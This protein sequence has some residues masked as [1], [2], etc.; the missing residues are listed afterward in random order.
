MNGAWARNAAAEAPG[1]IGYWK[2]S[3]DCRDHSGQGHDGVNHGVN[4]KTSEFNGDNAYVEVPDA[5]AFH[6]GDHDFSI[7]AEVSTE[8]DITD[9]FGDIVTKFDPATR[10]GINFTLCSSNPGYNSQSNVRNLFFGV[11]HGADGKWTP[12]GRPG[13]D[14]THISDA[15]TVFD[16]SLYAGTTDGANESDWAHVYRYAGDSV[17]ED[18]GRL[19]SGRTRGVYA[20]VVHDGALYAATCASH[21]EQKPEMDPGRVYRYRG[22]QSWEDLGAPGKNRRVNSLA[23]YNGKLYA[24][25]FNIYYS[26]PREPGHIYVYEGGQ[27]WRECGE[28]QGW[29]HAMA[30]HNGRL[31]AA[32]PNGEVF[33][34]DGSS[35]TNLGNPHGSLEECNQI[36]SLGVYQ[37]KLYAGSWPKGKVAVLRDGKWVDLGRLGD[38]TEVIALTVYNGSFYAGSIPRAEVFRFDPGNKWTS[39]GRLF[40]PPDFEP[41]PVGAGTKD[42]QDWTRA[43]SLAVY[44]GKLFASTATC[45]REMIQPP[46]A[47]EARGTVYAYTAGAGVSLDRDMGAGWKHV[48][49]VREGN[50]LR[51]YVDGKLAAKAETPEKPLDVSNDKPL[52][53]GAGPQAPFAG[54]IREVRLY[55]RTLK[56]EEIQKLNQTEG[57]AEANSEKH[58]A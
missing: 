53:I 12:C 17:W 30:V 4:L 5:E 45:Y 18:C 26:K 9:V 28:F 31:Y 25:A 35:W 57:V 27:S 48:A 20:M 33:A 23:S 55:N 19:G 52:L 15:L 44:Q 46:L 51:L 24:A 36:H 54:K 21:G 43:S 8:K 40:D 7:T 1:L 29:P 39:T 50:S 32:Y 11:D 38:A 58:P 6:L 42:V 34:Y 22:G 2:L 10:T 14:R 49:A 56:A 41:A 13:G 16:G 47:N 37:G 3:D